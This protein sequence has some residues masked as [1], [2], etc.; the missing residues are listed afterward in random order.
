ML[1]GAVGFRPFV[2]SRLS[3]TGR[4]RVQRHSYS[5][6]A[7]EMSCL[8]VTGGDGNVA[9]NENPAC[10]ALIGCEWT[11][12]AERIFNITGSGEV[13]HSVDDRYAAFIAHTV[14]AAG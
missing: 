13:L 14:A 4:V 2:E 11:L 12:C 5:R 6:D 1:P 8:P 3:D 10:H 7:S 9:V